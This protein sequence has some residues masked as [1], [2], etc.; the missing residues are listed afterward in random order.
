M[1]LRCTFSQLC[2]V[3]LREHLKAH[4]G[5]SKITVGSNGG[6][7]VNWAYLWFEG[8]S[9]RLGSIAALAE[10]KQEGTLLEYPIVCT[11]PLSECWRCGA[12]DAVEQALGREGHSG[13]QCPTKKTKESQGEIYRETKA[14]RKETMAKP[15]PSAD[16]F[17]HP[18]EPGSGSQ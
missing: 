4:T 13:D 3:T 11:Q 8:E 7:E 1:G 9:S 5:C 15:Q 2:N 14:K 6:R 17:F 16:G 12:I 18:G 10:L